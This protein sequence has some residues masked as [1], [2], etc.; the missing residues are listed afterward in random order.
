MQFNLKC[1]HVKAKQNPANFGNFLQKFAKLLLH[2]T[3][4]KKAACTYIAHVCVQILVSQLTLCELVIRKCPAE[5]SRELHPK[6]KNLVTAKSYL[7]T[8]F[9]PKISDILHFCLHW[10]SVVRFKTQNFYPLQQFHPITKILSNLCG[11]KAKFPYW[12]PKPR[13]T[14]CIGIGAETFFRNY[15][16]PLFERI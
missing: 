6:M 11:T 2:F 10:A 1:H 16:F 13:S 14:F 3:H 12:E 4:Q 7:Y 5:Y 8:R 9:G 15:I